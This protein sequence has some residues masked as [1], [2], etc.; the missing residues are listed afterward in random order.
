[1]GGR[2]RLV[3]RNRFEES[4]KLHTMDNYVPLQAEAL[5]HWDRTLRN[6]GRVFGKTVEVH[7]K[8]MTED[9]TIE[10]V[11]DG[12]VEAR[13]NYRPNDYVI[14]GS[15]GGKYA[16]RAMDFSARYRLNSEGEADPALA[17]DG[18]LLYAPKGKVWALMLTAEDVERRFP[19]GQFIGKWGGAIELR[20]GDILAMP[21]P[22]G[23]EVYLI[24]KDLFLRSYAPYRTESYV[25]SQGACA[26]TS[27]GGLLCP[28]CYVL[29]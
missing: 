2:V 17:R 28:A 23:G 16:M 7:A 29:P 20:A 13:A 19:A 26:R 21:W 4:Y 8:L 3:R 12:V 11:V 10:T 27:L 25:P 14:C 6:F 15:R 5:A 1:M 9:G 22:A 24:R 18:F